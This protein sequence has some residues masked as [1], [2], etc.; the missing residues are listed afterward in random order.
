MHKFLCSLAEVVL[1]LLLRL[2]QLLRRSCVLMLEWGEKTIVAY[3]RGVLSVFAADFAKD[4][5]NNSILLIL[6]GSISSQQRRQLFTWKHSSSS[7]AAA[8]AAA[9]AYLKFDFVKGRRN[10]RVSIDRSLTG[11]THPSWLLQCV[12][13]HYARDRVLFSL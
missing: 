3:S 2:F 8:A 10:L 13:V 4:K 5:M 1:L 7:T 11:G 9:A 6:Y 12:C